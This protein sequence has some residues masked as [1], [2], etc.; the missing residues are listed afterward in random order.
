[1]VQRGSSLQIECVRLEGF[2]WLAVAAGTN[3]LGGPHLS[4][5]SRSISRSATTRPIPRMVSAHPGHDHSAKDIGGIRHACFRKRDQ[6]WSLCLVCMLL[7]GSRINLYP[8][9]R[10]RL[11]P[12]SCILEAA[13][14][15][16]GWDSSLVRLIRP[17]RHPQ[18]HTRPGFG[19]QAWA[20]LFKQIRQR[21][22][23]QPVPCRSPRIARGRSPAFA[24]AR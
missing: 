17:T 24:R 16:D 15:Q 13:R 1:V 18:S 5:R 9:E 19:L 10:Q 4:V 21:R 11:V 2:I 23:R 8:V 20:K 3:I 7:R 6:D 12:K 22:L 14:L